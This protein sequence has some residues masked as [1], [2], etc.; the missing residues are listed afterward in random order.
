[1]A[2]QEDEFG[3]LN[4]TNQ[5]WQMEEEE[6]EDEDLR[7]YYFIEDAGQ[8]AS[9]LVS[10]KRVHLE[11][12]DGPFVNEDLLPPEMN[13]KITVDRSFVDDSLILPNKKRTKKAPTRFTLDFRCD[14]T[15]GQGDGVVT[16]ADRNRKGGRRSSSNR[17]TSTTISDHQLFPKMKTRETLRG[18]DPALNKFFPS[19]S[20]STN[21]ELIEEFEHIPF[22]ESQLSNQTVLENNEIYPIIVSVHGPFVDFNQETGKEWE[23]YYVLPQPYEKALKSTTSS[24]SSTSSS[25]LFPSINKF[26][27]PSLQDCHLSGGFLPMKVLFEAEL[28]GQRQLYGF[29]FSYERNEDGYL[30]IYIHEKDIYCERKQPF[31]FSLCLLQENDWNVILLLDEAR[32]NPLLAE[33]L[34]GE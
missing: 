22:R 34:M 5:E 24:S 27:M 11:D 2:S 17:D 30:I 26:S 10:K 8:Q 31:E 1:M 25:S 19:S 9:S 20:S 4:A 12:S 33:T 14:S 3:Q 6:E 7:G 15:F 29:I 32:S 28:I 16:Y 18:R 13:K 21:L 23:E